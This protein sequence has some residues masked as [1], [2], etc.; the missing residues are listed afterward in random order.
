M[1]ISR[2][3]RSL[4]LDDHAGPARL[5][6]VL[7]EAILEQLGVHPDVGQRRAELVRH[8]GHEPDPARGLAQAARVLAVEVEREH[9]QRERERA[10]P[11]E[12]RRADPADQRGALGRRDHVAELPRL[13]RLREPD[14]GVGGRG[15]RDRVL[16]RQHRPPL[17][18]RGAARVDQLHA[19]VLERGGRQRADNPREHAD[20]L[21]L[22]A[23]H[24]AIAGA[25]PEQQ[26]QALGPVP[27][28]PALGLGGREIDQA[29]ADARHRDRAGPRLARARPRAQ[30][31]T[32]GPDRR[33]AREELALGGAGVVT[34]GREHQAALGVEPEH[35]ARQRDPTAERAQLVGCGRRVGELV[36]ELALERGERAAGPA[37]DVGQPAVEQALQLVPA[38]LG[39]LGR[40][41]HGEVAGHRQ[42]HQH[43]EP[44]RA[45][46]GG[47]QLCC[48]ELRCWSAR[49]DLRVWFQSCSLMFL[50]STEF[51]AP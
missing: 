22:D 19:P 11:E 51:F 26:V 6:V 45:H 2:L 32:P 7:A 16:G 21:D 40:H 9:E 28:Q 1:S 15:G 30:D 46:R 31:R 37:A 23:D 50:A 34:R 39:A 18:H 27:A 43:E 38:Q 17:V 35:L 4:S 36:G 29:V 8:P 20:A 44:E 13:E 33:G 47:Y 25:P 5:V 24:P 14:R 12:Q 3:N 41:A 10:E 49:I 42:R 48:D